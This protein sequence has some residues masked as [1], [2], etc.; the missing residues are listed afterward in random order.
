[1]NDD[2]SLPGAVEQGLL[3]IMSTTMVPIAI[4]DKMADHHAAFF[5]VAM[6]AR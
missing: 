3:S 4:G 1:M 6:F 5:L 2:L